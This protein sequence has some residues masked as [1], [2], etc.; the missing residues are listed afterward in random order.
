MSLPIPSLDDLDFE[1]L[2]E[3][4]RALIPRYAP[5]WTDHNLHDPGITLL[6]LLAWLVDQQIYQIGFVGERHLRAFGALLGARPQAA[7][8][9]RGLIWPNAQADTA[10]ADLPRGTR[11]ACVQQP[12]IP[13]ELA[14]DIRLTPAR[15]QQ[16]QLAT[17]AGPV[18]LSAFLRRTQSSYALQQTHGTLELAFDRPLVQAAEDTALQPIALGIELDPSPAARADAPT[19]WGPLAFEYRIAASGDWRPVA[20]VED[21]TFA[22]AR[23]GT[24]LLRIP[25]APPGTSQVP[26]YLRLRLERGFFPLPPRIVRLELNVLPVVQLQT[27]PRRVLERHSNGMPDQVFELN[28]EDLP[29]QARPEHQPLAIE[30]VE[31]GRF[32]PWARHEDLSQCYPRDRVYALEAAQG[33]IVFGNG[34]NGRIPPE[35]AQI[36]HQPYHLTRGEAGNLTT[37]LGWRVIGAPV[38]SGEYGTN[39]APLSGGEAA[40]DT[41]RLLQ[42]A[43]EAILKRKVLLSDADL[44]QAA[45]KLAGY[46]VARAEVLSHFHPRLPGRELAGARSLVV[47][48]WRESGTSPPARVPEKYVRQVARAV[49]PYRVLGEPLSVIAPSYV[50][51]RIKAELL[52]A[53]GVDAEVVHQAA[54]ARL[55]ARLSDLTVADEIPPWPFGRPVTV[56]EIK[57]L[58]AAVPDV[59]AV[60]LCLL[61]REDGAFAAGPVALG[62][63]EVAIGGEHEL[64]LTP[65]TEH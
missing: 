32:E 23:T 3:E 9:A 5:E 17:G 26:S 65:L 42:A 44:R 51:V 62:R 38:G 57:T 36:R 33:R 16:A 52:I 46:G 39:L 56:S 30:V 12:E 22:L 28:L 47:V 37:G 27:Q 14:A 11:V 25:P 64:R 8:P 50:R 45:A 53:D 48:P 29:D 18:E 58:L 2:V 21:G 35:G 41:Q 63:D 61:A 59:A 1:R 34:V 49:A 13:F 24:V 43:R 20:L 31:Q 15:R 6:E 7:I 4:G 60:P 40:W 19:P 55:K 10:E 54:E